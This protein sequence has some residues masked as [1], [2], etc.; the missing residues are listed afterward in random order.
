MIRQIDSDWYPHF[1]VI[2]AVKSATTWIQK[3]LQRNESVFLPDPEPHYFSQEFDKGL[4]FYRQFFMLRPPQATVIGEKSADYLAHPFAADR[5]AAMLPDVR[6]VVQLRDPVA[7]AYSDY[8]MLYRRG[9]VKG[10]PEEYLLSPD[11]PQP[12]FLLDGL[13]G[14]H[15]GRW[16]ARFPREHVLAFLYEDVASYPRATVERVSAHIGVCARFDEA[17]AQRKENNSREKILPRPLRF[18]LAP[19]KRIARPFRERT[20]FMATRSLLARE[21]PYPPLSNELEQRMRAFYF[22]D[23]EVLEKLIDRDLSSWKQCRLNMAA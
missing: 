9:T 17:A 14:Q 11:N 4:D 15:L 2:G 1:I 22:Q 16:L 5:I 20:L 3:Q 6:L 19:L 21:L 7:R 18:A 10:L 13:Y 8:K 12:R 23:I